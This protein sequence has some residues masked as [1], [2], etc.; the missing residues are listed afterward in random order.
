MLKTTADIPKSV[1][2]LSTKPVLC[3]MAVDR[4][5]DTVITINDTIDINCQLR[6]MSVETIRL[7]QQ[8]CMYGN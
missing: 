4:A 1:P 7:S 2:A 6:L 5:C 8:I 3:K